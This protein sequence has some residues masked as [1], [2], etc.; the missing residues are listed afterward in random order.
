MIKVIIQTSSFCFFI[1]QDVL[2]GEDDKTTYHAI[3][4]L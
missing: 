4:K 2:S 1:V 3:L